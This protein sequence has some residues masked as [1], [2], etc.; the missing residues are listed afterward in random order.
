VTAPVV[1][2]GLRD[3]QHAGRQLHR[4]ALRRGHRDH[5]VAP[6][7]A[8]H[9]KLVLQLG[10]TSPRG[11]QLGMIT[12]MMRGTLPLSISCCLRMYRCTVR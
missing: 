2:A 9:R 11:N 3:T 1:V 12:A 4:Q 10:D 6:S 5:L 7:G 8:P